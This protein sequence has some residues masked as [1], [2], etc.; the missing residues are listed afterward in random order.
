MKKIISFGIIGILLISFI[1]TNLS[2][3]T[4]SDEEII[5]KIF[6]GIGYG[7]S[8]ENKKDYCINGSFNLT[9]AKGVIL[10]QGTFKV[11]SF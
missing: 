1:G 10:D 4:S 11:Y 2:T 3:A 9:D 8:V 5:M 6:G 7:F